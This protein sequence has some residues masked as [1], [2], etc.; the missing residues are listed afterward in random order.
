MTKD[1]NIPEHEYFTGQRAE[2]YMLPPIQSSLLDLDQLNRIDAYFDQDQNCPIPQPSSMESDAFNYQGY[3]YQIPVEYTNPYEILPPL[4][5]APNNRR[6]HNET[7]V[8]L[9]NTR[10]ANYE[11]NG[12][13]VLTLAVAA[14]DPR[15][16]ILLKYVDL[17]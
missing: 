4:P 8:I 9:F 13:Q 5:P 14:I 10:L 15:I 6:F 1:S 7:N 12:D 17:Q 16:P 11:V 2:D 3:T